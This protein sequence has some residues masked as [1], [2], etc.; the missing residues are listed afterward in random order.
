[1]GHPAGFTLVG[2]KPSIALI[3]KV[4]LMKEIISR[5]GFR[6]DLCMAYK[7]NL[8]KNPGSAQILSDGWFKYFGFRV[9]PEHIHC[10]GCL[11]LEFIP[12]DSDCPVRPCVSEKKYSTCAECGEFICGKLESRIVDRSAIQKELGIV[13]PEE[14]YQRF[15]LPY[16]N[17]DRLLSIRAGGNS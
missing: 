7:P 10:E 3:R 8:L 17:K 12:L 4:I 9:Q 6:C 16:E 11:N 5:C 15:I 1:M 13:I 2:S 14:D